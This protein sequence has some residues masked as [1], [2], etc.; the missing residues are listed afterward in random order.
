MQHKKL[1]KA[2]HC[3]QGPVYFMWYLLI[4]CDGSLV[5]IHQSL[6]QIGHCILLM[7]Q[8]DEIFYVFEGM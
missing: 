5:D 1:Q 7:V 8:D 4:G 3:S 6:D 2:L